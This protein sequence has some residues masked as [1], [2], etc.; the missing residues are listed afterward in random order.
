MRVLHH[1]LIILMLL[2]LPACQGVLTADWVAKPGTILFM[3]DFS[4]TTSGWFRTNIPS[5]NGVMDYDH[6][7]YR[8]MVLASNYDLWSTPGHDFRDVRIEVDATRLNGP[9]ENRFGVICR[10]QDPRNFYFFVISSDSYYALGKVNQGVYHLLGQTMMA[11]HAGISPGNGPNHLRLDCIGSTLTGFAN[12]QTLASA[13]DAG[14]SN[15]DVGLLAGTFDTPGTDVAFRH[16]QVIK[17]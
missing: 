14:F 17:P 2:L 16:F 1:C 13:Q 9:D 8:M 5:K 12:G 6:G 11:Y 4:N 3:D 7:T 15:G 10:F